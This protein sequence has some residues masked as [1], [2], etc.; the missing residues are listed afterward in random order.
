[1]E[2]RV[3]SA[4]EWSSHRYIESFLLRAV[5]FT[6]F[7]YLFAAPLYIS[8]IRGEVRR[9]LISTCQE[10]IA[11]FGATKACHARTHSIDR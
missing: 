6:R 10:W 11:R 1:M 4:S 5:L 2:L 8:D 9:V 3:H 7:L